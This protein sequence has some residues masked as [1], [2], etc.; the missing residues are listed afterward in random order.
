MQS[1]CNMQR[2][3]VLQISN[4]MAQIAKSYPD[5]VTIVEYG[6]TYEKRTI[7]LL[8]VKHIPLSSK[9]DMSKK[10]VKQEVSLD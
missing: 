6:K 8:K 10:K 3:S 9:A 5:V 1:R 7:S 2:C 4:W